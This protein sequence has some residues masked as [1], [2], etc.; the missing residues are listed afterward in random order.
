VAAATTEPEVVLMAL[1]KEAI[2]QS[3]NHTMLGL[4]RQRHELSSLWLVR[5]YG[6]DVLRQWLLR[7]QS[8]E[9]NKQLVNHGPIALAICK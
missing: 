3:G 6:L 1:P 5:Q 4:R 9:S 2:W 7:R 8:A